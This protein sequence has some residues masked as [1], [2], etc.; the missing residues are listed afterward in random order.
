MCV[1]VTKFVGGYQKNLVQNRNMQI[2]S[3]MKVGNNKFIA[4]IKVA[5]KYL[6]IGVAKDNISMLTELT[7]EE[8]YMISSKSGE[9]F[10][11]GFKNVME[12]LKNK[13]P[14]N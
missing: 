2:I 6:V 3:S 11:E 1:V 13:F 8:A 14:Q 5:D 9:S 4:V 12:K 10:G 7:D